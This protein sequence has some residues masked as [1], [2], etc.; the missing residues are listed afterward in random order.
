MPSVQKKQEGA[1][2]RQMGH[3]PMTPRTSELRK[4]RDQAR[5]K[6]IQAAKEKAAALAAA[7]GAK[8]GRPYSIVENPS[9]YEAGQNNSNNNSGSTIEDPTGDEPMPTFAPGTVDINATIRV[10]FILE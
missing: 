7:L 8:L 9:E 5:E 6:A 1:H 10:S 4:Y 2:A 3:N